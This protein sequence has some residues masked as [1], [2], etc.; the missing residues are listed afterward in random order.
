MKK[1]L[2]AENMEYPEVLDFSQCEDI[3]ICGFDVEKMKRVVFR[4]EKQ[5]SEILDKM[6]LRLID[7]IRFKKKCSYGVTKAK[8]NNRT[9]SVPQNDMGD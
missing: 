8:K 7:R 4:D 6:D 1:V 9:I 3:E 2:F 5:R